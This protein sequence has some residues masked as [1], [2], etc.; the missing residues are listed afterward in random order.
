MKNIF[1]TKLLSKF[2]RRQLL[3]GGILI[4]AFLGFTLFSNYGLLNRIKLEVRKNEL[5]EQIRTDKHTKDSL[6]LYIKRLE[7]D[8]S[9]IERVAREKY[10][11][12]KPG[13]KIYYIEQ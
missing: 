11:M 6:R 4:V 8:M 1:I 12:I 5:K 2:S 13:E 10:G 3:V 7:T 9:E